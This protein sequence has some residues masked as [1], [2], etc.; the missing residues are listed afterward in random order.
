[1]ILQRGQF[2]LCPSEHQNALGLVTYVHESGA[3]TIV[4]TTEPLPGLPFG[5][6]ATE[7]WPVADFGLLIRIEMGA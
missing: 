1:M 4:F 2:V 3:V 6:V 7:H 5:H